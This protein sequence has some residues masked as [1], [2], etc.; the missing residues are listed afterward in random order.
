MMVRVI[1][2]MPFI[3]WLMGCG[4]APV[5]LGMADYPALNLK[6]LCVDNLQKDLTEGKNE[7]PPYKSH[8]II[9]LQIK[10]DIYQ[11]YYT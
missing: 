7:L 6:T 4:P 8:V 9:N 10:K 5:T 11:W 3:F 2:L 1:F